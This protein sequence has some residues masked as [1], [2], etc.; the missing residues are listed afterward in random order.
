MHYQIWMT[1]DI[2][3]FALLLTHA[4]ASVSRGPAINR[5]GTVR[6]MLGHMGRNVHRPQI[7]DE[8]LGVIVLVAP[9][10][11]ASCGGPTVH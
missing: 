5:A 8:L 1:L 2:D 3:P 11:D 6:R 4:V 7:L 9:Q 10:R